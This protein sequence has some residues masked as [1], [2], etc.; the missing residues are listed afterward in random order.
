MTSRFLRWVVLATLVAMLAGH[1][2]ELFDRWDHTLRT[3]KD[4]D[5]AVVMVAACAGLVLS[6]ARRLVSAFRQ[7]CRI[8]YFPAL[9]SAL[10]GPPI[11]AENSATGPS[12]PLLCA[13][14][15]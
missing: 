3:G 13:L 15:I 7:A 9:H 1:V 10:P 14:R 5:Y 2:S 12:P 6:L 8:E 11:D 4:A